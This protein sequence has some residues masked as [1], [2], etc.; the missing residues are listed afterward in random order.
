[1]EIGR[2]EV[3]GQFRQN[4]SKIHL[5]QSKAGCGNVC[6]LVLAMWEAI[7]RRISV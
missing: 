1:M 4:V 5:S 6:L 2:T 3:Q 7:D